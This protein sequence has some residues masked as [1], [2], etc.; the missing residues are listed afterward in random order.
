[1]LLSPH[2][3]CMQNVCITAQLL[4]LLSMIVG[5]DR[6]IV[7]HG[8]LVVCSGWL[9]TK[10]QKHARCV[11]AALLLTADVMPKC[12][13]SVYLRVPWHS[14]KDRSKNRGC[15]KP[16][17]NV[18]YRRHSK[19]CRVQSVTLGRRRRITESGVHSESKRR[20]WT[21]C[22]QPMLSET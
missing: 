20:T 9:P 2:A 8:C 6:K 3:C 4:L 15:N 13:A 16:R 18:K 11:R 5:E 14:I 17:D 7:L 19:P 10:Q 21:S 22:R 1:M 12:Q